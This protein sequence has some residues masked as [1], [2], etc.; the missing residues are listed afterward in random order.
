MH[1]PHPTAGRGEDRQSSPAAI[2]NGPP[3]L[4]VL[5]RILP[6]SGL[7]LEVASGTGEHAALFARALPGLTWQPTDGAPANLRSIAAWAADGDASNLLPPLVLDASDPAS[8]PVKRADAMLAVN[9]IHIAPWRVAEGLFAGA[10]RLLPP[11]GPLVLYGPYREA[12]RHTAES[13]EAFDRDLR[14]RDP[15]WGVRDIEAVVELGARCGLRF[16]ERV[17]LP[18]N[19]LIVVFRPG[20][21]F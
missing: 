21:P 6:A 7:V 15:H 8:W 18:A 2:R 5:R 1:D 20:V 14:A 9:L 4:Q 17:A 3:I 13:N 19:N 12:G 10:A 16:E 11:G